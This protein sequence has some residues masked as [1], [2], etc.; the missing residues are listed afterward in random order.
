MWSRNR[1]ELFYQTLDGQVQMVAYRFNSD[2]FVAEKPRA[3][4]ETRL[5]NTGFLH[6]YDVAPD[7]KRVLGLFAAEDAKAPKLMRVLLNVDS[8]L[9]RRARPREVNER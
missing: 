3:W 8:E 2:S 4:S 1:R 9:R 5:G 6:G 7:G